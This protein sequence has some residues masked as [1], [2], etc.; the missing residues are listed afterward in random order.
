MPNI[1]VQIKKKVKNYDYS[2]FPITHADN[3]L[4]GDPEQNI[5]LS[6]TLKRIEKGEDGRTDIS[7]ELVQDIEE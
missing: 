1:S 7:I 3:V 6:E 2:L 4:I 5:T